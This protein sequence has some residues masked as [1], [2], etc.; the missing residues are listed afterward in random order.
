[1]S[2]KTPK[3]MKT[4]STVLEPFTYPGQRYEATVP[5]TLDLVERAE[6]ALNGIGGTIDAGLDWDDVDAV[7][8]NHLVEQQLTRADLLEKVAAASPVRKPEERSPHPRRESEENVIAR[9]LGQFAG[10][11][12]PTR[13]P[14]P[15]V[16]QCC[17]ANCSRGLYYA[18]EGAVRQDGDLAQ[19]NLLLNRAS[20]AVD[21]DSYLPYEGKVVIRN[22]RARR[23]TVR[24]PVWIRRNEI[25]AKIHGASRP[26]MWAGNRLLLDDLK[27][28]NEITLTFPVRES[29]ASYTIASGL[30]QA[31]QIFKCSFRSSTL[32]D[33][34]PR[35][36]D[37][38]DYP[39]YQRD[40]LKHLKAPLKK[41][42]RFVP[43]K[44]VLK[45]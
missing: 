4:N 7:I 37:P 30:P 14:K 32:V 13:I 29:T 23:I 2:D 16:M 39:L 22:K 15:W 19:V 38:T 1:M 34:F 12:S 6:L 24:I 40:H 43:D 20:P 26:A 17:T 45:W 41:V 11:S 42:T 8:R 25:S 9:S 35:S 10:L 5:D 31:E 3:A 28:G 21:V 27:P 44:T 36:E 33:I 18:W